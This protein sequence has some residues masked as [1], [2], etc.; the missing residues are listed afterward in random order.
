MTVVPS[1]ASVLT[2]EFK[3]SLVA[4]ADG[5]KLIAR[6]KV[7]RA[8][9]TLTVTQAEAFAV[10]GNQQKLCTLTQQAIMVMDGKVGK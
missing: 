8:G 5:E 3:L 7:V 1:T 10:N 4:P 2:V 6:G 9:R